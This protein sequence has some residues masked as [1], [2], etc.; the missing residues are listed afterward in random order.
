MS[1]TGFFCDLTL[2]IDLVAKRKE[3]QILREREHILS[4]KEEAFAL[5]S[6]KD[7]SASF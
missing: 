5:S 2:V 7:G 6:S 3:G 4:C 1:L